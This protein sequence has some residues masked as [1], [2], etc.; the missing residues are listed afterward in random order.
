[1]KL[2]PLQDVCR[3]LKHV[4]F[5]LGGARFGGLRQAKW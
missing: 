1:M 2:V 5:R 3:Q 4:Q